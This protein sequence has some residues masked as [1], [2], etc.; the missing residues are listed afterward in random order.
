MTANL[1]LFLKHPKHGSVQLRDC[2]QRYRKANSSEAEVVR[3]APTSS[4][5]PSLADRGQYAD[6]QDDVTPHSTVPL[7]FALPQINRKPFLYKD[8]LHIERQYDVIIP[9]FSY[10]I[11]A[12][13][14]IA[15]M[16][17]RLS[18]VSLSAIEEV[19]CDMILCLFS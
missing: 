15:Q 10:H 14:A 7:L 11:A 3:K 6:R 19:S 1:T 13:C 12:S 2:S 4:Y 17:C 5:L 18:L 8:G 16:S 9:R